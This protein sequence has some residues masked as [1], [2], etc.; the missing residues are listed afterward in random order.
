MTALTACSV[1]RFNGERFLGAAIDSVLAH[2]HRPIEIVV[3]D[4][5]S[6]DHSLAVAEGIRRPRPRDPGQERRNRGGFQHGHPRIAPASIWASWMPT[7]STCPAKSRRRSRCSKL[8]PGID[9]CLCIAENFWEAGLEAERD[10]YIE[11]GKVRAT[12][13]PGA[14]LARRS[15]FD[16]IGLLDTRRQVGDDIDWFLRAAD[17]GLRAQIL[18]DVYY[19]RRMHA[20]SHSHGLVNLDPY[21]DLAKE[22][23]EARRKAAREA[24]LH[25]PEV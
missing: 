9:Y 5:G 14:M 18:P 2:A 12:H 25:P 15:A 10:R 22:R 16:R 21:L 23:I 7:T 1:P 24:D 3:V 8:D 4:D 19:A 20:A 11:L 6:T 13:H 17:A